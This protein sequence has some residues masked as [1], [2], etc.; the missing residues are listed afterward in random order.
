MK[1]EREFW[2]MEHITGKKIEP[3]VIHLSHNKNNDGSEKE[4]L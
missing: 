4:L 2:E 3:L 1:Q